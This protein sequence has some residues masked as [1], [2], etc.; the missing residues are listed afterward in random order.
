LGIFKRNTKKK[1]LKKSQASRDPS[2][3]DDLDSFT[4]IPVELFKKI[5]QIEIRTKGLV[6]SVFGGEYH[7][8]FKGRGIEFREVRQYQIGDEIRSIDWNVSARTGE[9]FVKVF[10]E[11]RE[12]TLMM[13]VDIS[14]SEN[15]GTGK[16][17]KREIAA[18]ICA[19][20]AFSAIK[21]NDKVGLLLFS[22]RVELYVP[23]KK[24]QTHVLRIIRELFAHKPQSKGT[25]VQIALDHVM[26]VLRRRSIVLLISDFLE[27]DFA[28]SMKL[29]A[30]RHD[31][32][33]VHLYDPR[34]ESIPNVGLLEVTD[35]ET[36]ERQIIDTSKKSFQRL[37]SEA[38]MDR[39]MYLS[40]MFKQ[41]KLGVIDVD[42]SEDY[43][44]PL[45]KFFRHRNK[46]RK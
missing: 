40:G 9:T 17:F 37:H 44:D 13:V 36:G 2:L 30:N 7:S 8:A 41:M 15:F 31:T 14:G 25:D 18:E 5:K 23:P 4:G 20:I 21:N 24:G 42:I 34:E 11:E 35:A 12:Q 33:A 26:R 10:E 29:V 6:D 3:D 28:R 39:R 43:V 22:D 32:I 19:V 1:G 38:M 27:A 45:T 16:Q 46:G